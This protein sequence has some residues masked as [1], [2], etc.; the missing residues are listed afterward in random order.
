[1]QE[2]PHI[3]FKSEFTKGFLKTVSAFANYDGGEILF[4]VNDDGD[5]VGVGDSKKLCHRIETSIND[6][7]EPLPNYSIDVEDR[8][9]E[10]I[11]RLKIMSGTDTPYFASGKAYRRSHTSTVQVDTPELKKLVIKGM[12]TSFDECSTSNQELEFSILNKALEKKLG[13]NDVDERVYRTLCLYSS[14][15]GFNNAAAVLADKNEFQGIDIVRFGKNINEIMDRQTKEHVSALELYDEAIAMFERYYKFESIIGFEREEEYLVPETAFREAIANAIVHR[16]WSIKGSIKVSLYDDRIEITS[17]GGLPND[18]SEE[19]YLV[20]RLSILRNP[21]IA[22]VF[23]KLGY[24][25][26][27]GT[28]IPRI[29]ASYVDSGL[30]PRFD[31]SNTS[32]TATLP[33]AS[34]LEAIDDGERL[35]LEL[36]S[37]YGELRRSE[38]EKHLKTNKSKA[39][40]IL[41]RLEDKKLIEVEGVGRATKYKI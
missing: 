38:I 30:A 36:L 13:L 8:D 14:S 6:S 9:G 4:G 41:K 39:T 40:R 7:L 31:I 18:V 22:E 16:D 28:G 23:A 25:E 29:K 21:L 37:K 11:V 19:D 34:L 24:I 1:M 17:P 10:S 32:I 15:H 3:E 12:N 27:F 5:V 20:G 26:R 2:S 35:V 33:S